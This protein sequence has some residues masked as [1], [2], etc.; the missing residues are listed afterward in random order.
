MSRAI[1]GMANLKMHDH[2]PVKFVRYYLTFA[3]NGIARPTIISITF[4]IRR[5]T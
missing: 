4:D 5:H 3:A 2:A 1:E